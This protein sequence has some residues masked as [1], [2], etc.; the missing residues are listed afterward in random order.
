MKINL[1]IKLTSGPKPAAR[2]KMYALIDELLKLSDT[3]TDPARLRKI[4]ALI[5][6]LYCILGDTAPPL[7]LVNGDAAVVTPT[8]GATVGAR[9]QVDCGAGQNNDAATK[10]VAGDIPV[11]VPSAVVSIV[12]INSTRPARHTPA[13]AWTIL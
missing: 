13:A 9:C 6:L 3:V 8:T 11:T 2:A 1:Y 5:R 12:P 4:E 7:D 10:I